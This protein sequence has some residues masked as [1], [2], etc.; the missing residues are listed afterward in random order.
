MRREKYL[1]LKAELESIAHDLGYTYKI[2][3]RPRLR[4][5]PELSRFVTGS[6]CEWS[7][8]LRV[9]VYGKM[10]YATILF[11]LAHEVR[12]AIHVREGLFKS[13]YGL[14]KRLMKLAMRGR[15]DQWRWPNLGVA[16]RA[17]NDCDRW[18]NKFLTDRG[19]EWQKTN[20]YPIERT[21][22]WRLASKMRAYLALKETS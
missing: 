20:P 6:H 21:A 16:I 3:R 4:L 8:E 7:R 1:R 9:F 18:A 15:K 2:V 12:H 13:N 22:A 10:S 17:E 14:N 5:H 19:E 11:T